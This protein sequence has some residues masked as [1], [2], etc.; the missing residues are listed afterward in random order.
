VR[1]STSNLFF[2]QLLVNNLLI[3]KSTPV[4]FGKVVES[5]LQKKGFDRNQG[6]RIQK[7]TTLFDKNFLL[8][9]QYCLLLPGIKVCVLGMQYRISVLVVLF[10]E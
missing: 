6:D 7:K 10:R 5:L 9:T 1:K 3:I 2:V 8:C 4:T